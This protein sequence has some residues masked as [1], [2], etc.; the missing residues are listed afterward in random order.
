MNPLMQYCV[1][2]IMGFNSNTP[3]STRWLRNI[4]GVMIGQQA[5]FHALT[6]GRVLPNPSRHLLVIKLS[7]FSWV[8]QKKPCYDG[9]FCSRIIL[10]DYL[11]T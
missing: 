3:K 9:E 1:F 10:G 5:S 8:S 7:N 4:T 11:M 6:P 2:C